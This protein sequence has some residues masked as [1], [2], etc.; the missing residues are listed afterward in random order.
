MGM[1]IKCYVMLEFNFS[2]YCY[3]CCGELAVAK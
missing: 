1:L 3:C 2:N